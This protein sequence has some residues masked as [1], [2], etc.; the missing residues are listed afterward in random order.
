VIAGSQ[1]DRSCGSS[2][3]PRV[4]A[5][6][7]VDCV[8]ELGQVGVEG[9]EQALEGAPADVAPAALDAGEVGGCDVG[10]RG[11]FL[12]RESGSR[13]KDAQ[14]ISDIGLSRTYHIVKVMLR[15]IAQNIVGACTSRTAGR[16]PG[17]PR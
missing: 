1:R 13:A 6:G 4:L 8:L 7:V 17:R 14:R 15:R 2:A 12:L 9:A 5:V 11:Q 16:C 3:F 10:A